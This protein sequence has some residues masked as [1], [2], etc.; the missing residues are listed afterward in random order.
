[1]Q[2]IPESKREGGEISLTPSTV[3]IAYCVL[4]LYYMY[5]Y[6]YLIA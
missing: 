1:M 2:L 4:T 6:L 3:T 5:C